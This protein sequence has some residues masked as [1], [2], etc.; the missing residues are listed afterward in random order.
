MQNYTHKKIAE[1]IGKLDNPPADAGDFA[2]WIKAE[3][4]LAFLRQ[5]ALSDEIVVHVLT[6]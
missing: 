1:I 3:A 4:H 6:Q 2:E 5:N